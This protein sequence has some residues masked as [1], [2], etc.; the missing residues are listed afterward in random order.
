MFIERFQKNFANSQ[1]TLAIAVLAAVFSWIA[2]VSTSSV[3]ENTVSETYKIWEIITSYRGDVMLP[4]I[5]ICA[6]SLICFLL[7]E[8]NI[9]FDIIRKRTTLHVSFFLFFCAC[10][11]EVLRDVWGMTAALGILL[12]TFNLFQAYHKRY[13][14]YSVFYSFLFLGLSF[15]ALPHLLTLIPLFLWGMYKLQSFSMRTFLAAVLGFAF[16]LWILFCHAFYHEQ[17]ELFYAPF[18]M[19]TETFASGVFEPD[20]RTIPAFAFI[21]IVFMAGI[22]HYLCTSFDDKLMTRSYMGFITGLIV[23]LL[24]SCVH[25]QENERLLPTLFVFVSLIWCHFTVLS[26]KLYASIIFALIF[27]AMI[28]LFLSNFLYY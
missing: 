3:P 17:M 10:F 4:A 22:I 9:R 24:C 6:F 2:A 1:L 16:P 5:G 8:F 20:F 15:I 7:V 13:A 26:Q 19:F 18:T 28:A 25:A 23:W 14:S 12:A 27:I 21:I 11:P